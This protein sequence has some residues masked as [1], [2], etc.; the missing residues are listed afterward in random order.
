MTPNAYNGAAAGARSAWRLPCAMHYRG[1][2]GTTRCR[3]RLPCVVRAAQRCAM[4][5]WT[6]SP[7]SQVGSLSRAARSFRYQASCSGSWALAM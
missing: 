4:K 7:S 6:T 3:L 1:G 5:V 2:G